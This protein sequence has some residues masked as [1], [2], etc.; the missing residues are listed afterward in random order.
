MRR[1][2]LA[3][4]LLAL[5]GCATGGGGG[6]GAKA[7]APGAAMTAAG[8]I[9]L[10][11]AQTYLQNNE[12]ETAL[13]RANRALATDPNAGT[14]HAMLGLIYARIGDRGRA[15]SSFQR[16]LALAPTEGAVLNAY[17]TWLCSNGDPAG[18]AAQFARALADP[19]FTRPGLVHYNAGYCAIKFGDNAQAE[20]ELRRALDLPGADPG[21]TL[22]ALAQAELALGQ[23]MEA[24]AFIQRREAL[25][26][27]NDVLDLAARIEDA[28]GNPSAAARYRERIRGGGGNDSQPT[29]EGTDRQ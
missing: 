21:N 6:T 1:E 7:P 17:G 3:L 9:N 4:V 18:A 15:A 8:T 29:R 13:N 23:Y 25:G 12:L 27:T 28:A 2:W 16:A 24:R 19:F 26:A 11:L 22:M 14:V 10:G 20:K 5:V